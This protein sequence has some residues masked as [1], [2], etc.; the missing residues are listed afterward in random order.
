MTCSI[1]SSILN[2]G[3]TYPKRGLHNLIQFHGK[4]VSTFHLGYSICLFHNK[5]AF[6]YSCMT[7]FMIITGHKSLPESK[8]TGSL[9]YR[10]LNAAESVHFNETTLEYYLVIKLL[11]PIH[12]YCLYDILHRCRHCQNM[13]KSPVG[14]VDSRSSTMDY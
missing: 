4:H 11:D 5:L 12:K 10:K 7:I 2:K 13:A 1:F 9:N 3:N 8:L 14:L 6:F